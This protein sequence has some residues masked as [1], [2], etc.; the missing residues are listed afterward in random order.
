MTAPQTRIE[1]SDPK[2]YQRKLEGLVAEREPVAILSETADALR[3]MLHQ[4]PTS[5]FRQR[6]FPGKWTPTEIIGHMT[7]AEW[8]LGFRT[9]TV[10]CDES[11]RLMAY[12]QERWVAGQGHNERE[13]SDL[14]ETF[15]ALRTAN[16]AL[17]RRLSPGQLQR[18]ALHA[19]RGEE[20]LGQMLC[21]LAGHDLSHLDQIR[22]YLAAV[23]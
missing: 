3:A 4:K 23:T 13:P 5:A 22:R 16:L 14:V 19:E 7:D 18:S 15:A 20:S 8:T 6:P 10:L 11:P 2:A 17:W 9:R 21:L 1:Q 12:D